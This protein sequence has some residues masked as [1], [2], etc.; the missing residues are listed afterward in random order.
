[1]NFQIDHNLLD[2]DPAAKDLIAILS[3]KE[4]ELGL[5][6]AYL[7]HEFP[8]YLG[9]EEEIITAN[10]MIIS[11]KVGLLLF[12]CSPETIADKKKLGNLS[13]EVD[14][15]YGNV[16]SKLVKSKL[17]RKKRSELLVPITPFLFLPNL[18]V[19]NTENYHVFLNDLIMLNRDNLEEE[20]GK[21][22]ATGLLVSDDNI[23]KETLSVLEGAKGI[24]RPKE[25]KYDD[26]KGETKGKILGK[27]ESEIAVFDVEQKR[28]AMNICQE[29]QR[30]RGLAGSGKTIVLAMK[31][32][33]IHIRYPDA[34]ILYT[35]FTKSLYS[36][37][38]KLITRFY[39]Q[40]ADGD[41][42]WE[43]IKILHAWGGRSLPGVYYNVCQDN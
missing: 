24:S 41:P 14:Q 3:N 12:K 6:D 22:K 16:Y 21:C 13:D 18:R 33:L 36:F 10:V 17:L 25:R 34:E 40:F 26:K 20:I 29:F 4:E 23:L 11:K 38:K 35:F 27:I 32:A 9:E 1:M 37:I 31:A 42:N 5:E 19:K 7:Y 8:F 15:I 30:I 43:K 2:K 39:R 28:A